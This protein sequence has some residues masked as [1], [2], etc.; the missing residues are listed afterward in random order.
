M[1]TR[2]VFGHIVYLILIYVYTTAVWKEYQDV[3]ACSI[4]PAASCLQPNYTHA[5]IYY[6]KHFTTSLALALALFFSLHQL[7]TQS[8][9][10]EELFLIGRLIILHKWQNIFRIRNMM[11]QWSGNIM[12]NKMKMDSNNLFYK[13]KTP[14]IIENM[15]MKK[16]LI[17]LNDAKSC[18]L[19]TNLNTCLF[20]L[21]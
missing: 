14:Q 4:K 19:Q 21:Y 13:Q 8:S 7:R 5:N 10:W 12:P 16:F 3:I 20:C 17:F 11:H 2:T 15:L 1:A 9:P 18:F 6:N